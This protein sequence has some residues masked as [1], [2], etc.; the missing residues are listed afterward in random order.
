VTRK[1]AKK[2]AGLTPRQARF[3]AEYQKDQNATQAAI[4]AG[5]EFGQPSGFYVYLLADPRTGGVFYVGKGKHRRLRKHVALV[6]AGRVDNVEKCR[7]IAAIHSRGEEVLELVFEAGLTERTALEVERSLIEALMGMGLT[8]IAGGNCT[9]AERLEEEV[10]AI[11]R[12]WLPAWLWRRQATPEQV[13]Y[14]D[15]MGGPD[16]F[17]RTIFAELDEA[18]AISK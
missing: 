16:A 4:R 6:R 1:P 11:K 5:L 10:A 15:Q 7:R 17:R 3:V 18:L 12:N 14:V 2:P 9:N 8:N 13:A